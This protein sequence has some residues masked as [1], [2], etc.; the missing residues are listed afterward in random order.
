MAEHYEAKKT[1]RAILALT[2][3]FCAVTTRLC[4]CSSEANKYDN[5]SETQKAWVRFC[6]AEMKYIGALQG[7][8]SEQKKWDLTVEYHDAGWLAYDLGHSWH[9]HR[10]AVAA[11]MAAWSFQKKLVY[12]L[13]EPDRVGCILWSHYPEVVS[14]LKWTVQDLEDIGGR[15]DGKRALPWTSQVQVS[16]GSRAMLFRDCQSEWTDGELA[17][18]LLMRLLN[19]KFKM[20]KQFEEWFS[21]NS[22]SLAWDPATKTFVIRRH[23]TGQTCSVEKLCRHDDHYIM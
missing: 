20:R 19:Q 13:Q 16:E 4:S 3:C 12:F 10:R 1:Q 9:E 23:K 8:D 18:K 2:V 6:E 7:A 14:R 22:N 11:H 5:M 17:Q 21:T 15:I